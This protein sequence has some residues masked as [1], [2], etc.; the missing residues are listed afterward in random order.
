MDVSAGGVTQQEEGHTGPFGKMYIPFLA[1][2]RVLYSE[3][4]L[5]R[6]HIRSCCTEHSLQHLGLS[7]AHEVYLR[8]LFENSTALE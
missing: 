2:R 6:E 8:S 3:A 5:S 4:T 1:T 7:D